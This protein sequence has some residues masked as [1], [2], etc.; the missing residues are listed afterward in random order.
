MPTDE[1]PDIL[2]EP[3]TQLTIE[4]PDDS[5][6]AVVTTLV[7]RPSPSPSGRAVIH[8][9][10]F[11]DYFFHTE[12]AEWWTE[13]G[14]DFYAVDLRK[15]G[16]SLREHQTPNFIE[17]LS[18]YF[19][20]LDAVWDVVTGRHDS[21]VATAHSTGALVLSLWLHDRR[22]AQLAGVFLNSPW[23]D[24]QGSAW[25]R[26]LPGKAALDRI[27]ARQPRL[28]IPRTVTGVYGRSLHRDHQGE[29][30]YDLTWKPLQSFP[31]HVGWLRAIRRGHAQLHRGLDLPAPVLVLSSVRS[32]SP[33]ELGED[34]HTTDIVL[35]VRQIRRWASSLGPHVT[36][37]AVA[38]ARH[39]V[40]LSR[41][42]VR[43]QVYAELER[44]LSSYVEGG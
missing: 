33:T 41:P 18:H 5:E 28:V 37:V 21:V 40:V 1:I 25:L 43:V 13:R 35:D 22:P 6:G 4:L 26:S 16:R 9:H 38:D 2:G 34:A 3:Y 12:Y 15:Y 42:H 8:V 10:G 14:Y 17:D 39:D 7:H 31:L 19:E 44:W 30:D 27:G 36:S 24:M 29:F 32:S 11:A 23:L 20:D